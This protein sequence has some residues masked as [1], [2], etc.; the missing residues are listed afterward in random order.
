M[1]D[2]NE[3]TDRQCQQGEGRRGGFVIPQMEFKLKCIAFLNGYF[4]QCNLGAL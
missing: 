2:D 1:V 4:Y 3:F